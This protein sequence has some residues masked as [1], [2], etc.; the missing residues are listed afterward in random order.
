METLAL[1]GTA[2]LIHL[3]A[4]LSPGPDFVVAVN[5]AL[6]YSRKISL[7]TALGFGLGIGVH[8][9]YCALGIGYLIAQSI[10]VFATLKVLGSLYLAYIGIQLIRSKG[11]AV[12]TTKK[13][14]SLTAYQAFR[15]GFL[16]NVLNPKATLFMVSL[17]SFVLTPAT[18]LWLMLFISAC[19]ILNTILWFS[20]IGLFVSLC[21]HHV[22]RYAQ[23]I[24]Q[25]SGI[26]LIAL[27]L[28]LL[29][30]QKD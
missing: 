9:T 28:K 6:S 3:L 14:E 18:P 20:F 22:Q 30:S 12:Q 19:M 7:C 25:T 8:I 10:V 13:K 1:I 29:A 27:S 17:F 5:H 16:T 23:R 24:D 21:A 2:L 11:M 4:L 15:K 26:I